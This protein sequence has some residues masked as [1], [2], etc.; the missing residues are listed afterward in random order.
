MTA[1]RR[2]A[3]GL[4]GAALLVAGGLSAGCSGAS[5]GSGS[6]QDASPGAGGAADAP[7]FADCTGLASAPAP[8]PASTSTA[9][10]TAA[11]AGP[12]ALGQ[13]PTA[14]PSGNR[15]PLPALELPC[16]TGGQKLDIGQIRGPAL[17]NLWASWCAPCREELPVV[18]RLAG[19]AGGRVHVIGVASGDDRAAAQS[20]ARDLKITFPALYD[21]KAAL[22]GRVGRAGLPVTLFVDADDQIAYVYNSAPLDGGTLTHLVDRYLGVEVQL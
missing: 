8:A 12:T 20:L 4:A 10:S 11:S 1:A 22:L 14:A 9:A 2:L 17:I 7:P 13:G 18:Q 3:A 21:R 19:Q 15:T 6:S 5:G 16:F